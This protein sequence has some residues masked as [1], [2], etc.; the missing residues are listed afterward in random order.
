MPARRA[1]PASIGVK[2]MNPKQRI[3][4]IVMDLM[5]VAELAVCIFLGHRS[6]DDLT[7]F[8][9][10]TYLPAGAT[11]VLLAWLLI[12]RWRDAPPADEGSLTENRS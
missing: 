7:A 9:L 10:K 1:K 5:L 6:P 11:T 3:A 12:R 2:P 8:F 4:V